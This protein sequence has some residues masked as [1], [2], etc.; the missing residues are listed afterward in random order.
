M[1]SSLPTNL[2]KLFVNEKELLSFES[3][4]KLKDFCPN[5]IKKL[6]PELYSVIDNLISLV[7]KKKYITIDVMKHNFINRG[8]TCTDPSFHIDG[9]NNEY[10]IWSI[11]DFRTE[12]L[13]DS[14]FVPGLGELSPRDL[15]KPIF[16]LTNEK[17]FSLIESPSSVPM[18]YDSR[19]IH[20]G[21]IAEAGHKRVM[22]RVCSSD[23]IKPKN[24]KLRV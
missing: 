14:I 18:K 21:R 19:C 7:E 24:V 13:M 10:V 23:L 2:S 4:V 3:T 12:F 20:R 15:A 8:K 17:T 9:V 11:G 6:V 22:V 1:F 16:E 5:R